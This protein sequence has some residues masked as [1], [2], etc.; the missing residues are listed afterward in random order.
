MLAE[1]A[2]REHAQEAAPSAPQLR[3]L[4]LT[5][6]C[7]SVA[8]VEKLGDTAAAELFQQHDRLVLQLQQQWK[9]RL[10]DRSD[11]LLLLFERPIN[12]LAFAM[13]YMRGLQELGRERNIVLKAR[14]GMHVGEVLTWHNSAEAVQVGA[15]PMEVEG[16]AKPMAARL[17]V[18]ARP[19]Q[20]L[21]S[22]VAESL[23]RRAARELG[24]RSERLLW[25]SHGRWRFKGVPTAQEIYEAGEIGITP[26]RGPRSSP[27]AWRDL[28]LWRRPAALVAEVALLAV[29]GIGAWFITRPEPAI[30]FA[31]RDWVVMGNVR[32][33]TGDALLD[34]SLEQAFRIS[35]EQSRHVNLLSDLKIQETRSL[36]QIAPD[37]Q[38]DRETGMQIALRDGARALI[39][40]TV[41]TVNGSV[42]VSVEVVDPHS[43]AT[44][45]SES[46]SAPGKDTTAVLASIDAVTGKLRGRLGEA[47]A[48][49]AAT[50]PLPKVATS[51]L[52][53]LRA[54]AL[55]EKAMGRRDYEEAR[56]LYQAAL[57]SDPKFALA[58]VGLGRLLARLNS[59]Q[60]ALE[61]VTKALA[62]R[63]SLPPRE[64]LYLD[65]WSEELAPRGWPTEHWIALAKLYPDFFAGPS[66]ASWYLMMDNRFD[67]A[68]PYAEA[69]AVPQD[70]LRV[71]PMM[72]LGRIF[73]AQGRQQEALDMML[74]AEKLSGNKI[75]DA[76][77]DV[78]IAM[79]RLD[80][81]EVLLQEALGQ[82]E[83][84]GRLTV[85]RGQLLL[86]LERGELERALEIAQQLTKAAQ[87]F[88][89][90]YRN[91]FA[92]LDMTV[93]V[94]KDPERIGKRDFDALGKQMEAVI[95]PD[96]PNLRDHYYRLLTLVYLAQR[97][98]TG[99]WA[100]TLLAR[101]AS[102]IKALKNPVL[103]AWLETVQARQ[104]LHEGNP[105][106]AIEKLQSLL[107][108]S[109]PVQARVV[110]HD[111]L[112]AAG[113]Q[114]E[115][116]EQRR[117]LREHRGRAFAEVAA[118]QVLQVLNVAD[119]R[120]PEVAAVASR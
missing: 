45:Y 44:V 39:L 30:A 35:L 89:A 34:D 71:F 109:E 99:D 14:A 68:V 15:K 82:R 102:S 78:L 56:R 24:E 51:N 41:A 88:P 42:R 33:L 57:E 100:G 119:S 13:D 49:I 116:D 52:D 95:Q 5:D 77:A 73:L 4:L 113:R 106:A 98:G 86:A 80:Q 46:V 62:L 29:I 108:G 117:W 2:M 26:L 120:T 107:D 60:E 65:A 59:R 91:H 70:P 75:N 114:G 10:I 111:A 1:P 58:H 72:H 43:G 74:A 64:R 8:L 36:I 27:K 50:Q 66:N 21:L 17:M 103:D 9:G 94:L 53:A 37:V 76:R 110:L 112:L 40:P 61:H 32:N 97:S 31:E 93:R 16:L 84:V 20:I 101:H 38:I 90:D 85:M 79:G 7:D 18:L 12:G 23:T 22:A 96:D 105:G 63:D 11:G 28:P 55:A 48:S 118:S 67:A 54:F 6:L 87:P 3:T 47:M 115:A 19:G 83:P 81:A 69:A 92:L 104:L 25:K